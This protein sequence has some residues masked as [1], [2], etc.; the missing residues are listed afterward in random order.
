MTTTAP[1]YEVRE[2]NVKETAAEVR[3]ALRAEFPGVKFAVRMSRGTGYGW[4][5]CSWTDGPTSDQVRP[6]LARFE[7]SRF[8][9]FD[10]AYHTV[11]P[12]LYA[13]EDGTLYEPRYSCCGI[14]WQRDYSPEAEAWATQTAGPDTIWW[15]RVE[16]YGHPE[17]DAPRRL[18]ADTDLTNGI[19]TEVPED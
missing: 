16:H 5:R 14:N 18:L 2:F 13:R 12:T 1:G 6:I 15:A 7:S 19:P 10:D 17:Y 9:G 11:E 4:L 8:D 3:K